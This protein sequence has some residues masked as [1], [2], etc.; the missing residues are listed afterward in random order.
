MELKLRYTAIVE[1][2]CSQPVTRSTIMYGSCSIPRWMRRLQDHT[3]AEQEAVHGAFSRSAVKSTDS[4]P[5]TRYT[6]RF[7][8]PYV[9]ER[10]PGWFLSGSLDR[11]ASG[12]MVE[13]G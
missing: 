1:S 5:V 2:V 9:S 4:G 6:H 8:Y 13:L 11:P 7:G 10:V 3:G 12:T